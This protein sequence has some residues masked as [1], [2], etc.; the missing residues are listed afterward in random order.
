MAD[1]ITR[2]ELRTL[3]DHGEATVV[4]ALGVDHFNQGHIPG[5]IQIDYERVAQQAP[6]RLPDKDA[7]IE[8]FEVA[9]RVNP[10][11]PAIV[12]YCASEPCPNSDIAA[13][14]LVALGYSDVREY[15][16]GKAGWVEAGL[17]LE[18]GV[19]ATV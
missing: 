12:V 18:S 16:E 19:G 5:A 6:D 3:V 14:K 4:E 7:A 10:L 1:R 13:N 15:A 8:Q 9:S 2:D 11:D 17:P